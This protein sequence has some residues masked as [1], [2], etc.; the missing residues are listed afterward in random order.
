[1][2]L[3]LSVAGVFPANKFCFIDPHSVLEHVLGQHGPHTH[4]D[5][6]QDIYRSTMTRHDTNL[7]PR[8]VVDT[9]W[10]SLRR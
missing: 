8:L 2:I 6:R 1:M 3:S 7:Q 4:M 9:V 10:I 5:A